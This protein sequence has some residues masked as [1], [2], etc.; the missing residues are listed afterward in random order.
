MEEIAVT[1]GTKLLLRVRAL[2]PAL[3]EQER[4]VGQYVVDH[5]AEV[6]HLAVAELAQR[7]AVSDAT[8]VR[9]CKRVGTE[10]YPNL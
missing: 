6:I 5:P 10:G 2:L 8:V 3:N 9:F 4:K 7:C 1:A